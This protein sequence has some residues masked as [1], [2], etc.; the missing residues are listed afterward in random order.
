M[1]YFWTNSKI[2][3]QT[4]IEKFVEDLM[5]KTACSRARV[6]STET[7]AIWK[8][9][10]ENKIKQNHKRIPWNHSIIFCYCHL[11]LISRFFWPIKMVPTLPQP[12]KPQAANRSCL[13]M[14]GPGLEKSILIWAYTSKRILRSACGMTW[15]SNREPQ[16]FLMWPSFTSS[17]RLTSLLFIITPHIQ[18]LLTTG[19]DIM[20]VTKSLLLSGRNKSTTIVV[21]TFSKKTRTALPTTGWVKLCQAFRNSRIFSIS[22]TQGWGQWR[23]AGRY[24]IGGTG[25]NEKCF[26]HWKDDVDSDIR[27]AGSQYRHRFSFN[28]FWGSFA[29][30]EGN[31]C[32]R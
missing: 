20:H 12:R 27:T 30:D 16:Y 5:M 21:R 28:R 13:Y 1:C 6:Y 24:L 4:A 26:Q 17:P 2:D 8:R 25:K 18:P 31:T 11:Y 32:T 3:M 10:T 19:A 29:L 23:S 15:P 22:W 9:K 7:S 14:W